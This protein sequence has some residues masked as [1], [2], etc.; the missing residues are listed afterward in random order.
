MVA[1]RFLYQDKEEEE[2]AHREL[3]FFQLITNFY[4]I[5]SQ[6]LH[7]FSQLTFLTSSSSS[8]LLEGYE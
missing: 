1:L 7:E 3:L 4:Y 5:L 2:V 6:I 8:S